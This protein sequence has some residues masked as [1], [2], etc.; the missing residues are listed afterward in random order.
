MTTYCNMT[1]CSTIGCKK[2]CARKCT[3]SIVNYAGERGILLCIAEFSCSKEGDDSDRL[4]P[5]TKES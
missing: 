5:D 4:F 2:E 3:P 1:F